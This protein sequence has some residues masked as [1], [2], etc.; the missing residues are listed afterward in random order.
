MGST[1]TTPDDA[2]FWQAE[3]A[4]VLGGA[5]VENNGTNMRAN[6][7]NR[8]ITTSPWSLPFRG[9]PNVEKYL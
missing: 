7:S 3:K 1:F 5:A 8:F 2:P 6:D 9:L 4:A